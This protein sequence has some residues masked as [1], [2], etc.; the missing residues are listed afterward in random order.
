[1]HLRIIFIILASTYY[2][3]RLNQRLHRLYRLHT[4]SIQSMM[5]QFINDDFVYHLADSSLGSLIQS[6]IWS[7]GELS[8]VLRDELSSLKYVHIRTVQSIDSINN[9]I[10]V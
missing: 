9:T 8:T 10:Y 1:M 6:L 2:C 7:F 5:E 3:E 4:E